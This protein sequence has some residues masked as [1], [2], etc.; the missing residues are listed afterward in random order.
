MKDSLLINHTDRQARGKLS[1]LINLNIIQQSF[2]N[3]TKLLMPICK[4]CSHLVFVS[5]LYLNIYLLF[6]VFHFLHNKKK[7]INLDVLI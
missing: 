4:L 3:R 2:I 7:K 6:F 5:L 1:H